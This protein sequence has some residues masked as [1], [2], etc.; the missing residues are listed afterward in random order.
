M[1]QH[2]VSSGFD[3]LLLEAE[4]QVDSFEKNIQTT[5]PQPL[6]HHPSLDQN[7]NQKFLY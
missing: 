2:C 3:F 1:Q 5:Q 7:N 4:G 6:S